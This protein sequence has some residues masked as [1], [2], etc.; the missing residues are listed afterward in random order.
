MISRLLTSQ[1]IVS[2]NGISVRVML[3]NNVVRV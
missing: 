2:V 1:I 3:T